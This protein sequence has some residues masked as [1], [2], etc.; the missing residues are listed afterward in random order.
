MVRV[1]D[2]PVG[3]VKSNLAKEMAPT[4]PAAAPSLLLDRF[5]AGEVLLDT[6]LVRGV[7]GEGGMGF[8][9]DGHDRLLNRNVAIK[10]ARTAANGAHL[11]RE[12]EALAAFRHSS[13]VTVYAMA[14]HRGIDFL[15]LERVLGQSLEEHLQR[16]EI[17]GVPFEVGEAIEILASLAEGLALVHGSG[18]SHRDIKPANVMLAP[19][20]RVVLL[21]FGL[22]VPD[23]APASD[24]GPIFGSAPY[25]A[26]EVI[27]A[28]VRW[29]EGSQVDLYAL[30]VL[31]FQVLTGALPFQGKTH[32]HILSQHLSVEAPDVRT[33][34]PTVPASLAEAIA[35]LLAKR[36]E[37]RIPTAEA[38]LWRLQRID[39]RRQPRAEAPLSAL[40]VDD[41][42]SLWEIIAGAIR[43]TTSSPEIEAV[44]DAERALARFQKRPPDLLVMDLD[45]P[46]MSGLELCMYLRATPAHSRC[47]VVAISGHASEGDQALLQELGLARFVGKGPGFVDRLERALRSLGCAQS[48]SP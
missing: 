13:V 10:S 29:G 34:R 38:L 45:L 44:S 42:P 22:G 24:S 30:G 37:E 19:N 20:Q 5:V 28:S 31:G 25:M 36:P 48:T 32:A 1:R 23:A 12:G 18:L 17:T 41:D 46:G 43:A 4:A 16:R 40:I 3:A 6:Y 15:V 11:R 26:P 27:T 35:G 39:R 2:I 14:R 8:V 47:R 7:L 9:Y 21:D 33:L